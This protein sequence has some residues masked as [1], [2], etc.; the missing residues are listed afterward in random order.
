MIL[1]IVTILRRPAFAASGITIAAALSLIFLHFDEFYFV[2][3]YL[4]FYVD[5]GRLP[6]FFLDVAISGLSGIV[7][8]TSVY[9]ISTFPALKGVHRRAGL[10]GV[11]AA[12][13]AGACPC[14]Y[15]VP[16]LAVAGG[17][18]G[19]LA[20]FGI[21]FY[22]YQ[23]PIKLGSLALLAFTAFTQERSLRAACE[24]PANDL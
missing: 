15:L 3:P 11:A 24:L 21:L 19:I 5:P 4:A 22:D 17:A 9:E 8:T 13:V 18:G 12:F 20:A 23:I 6:V 14:Y 16:L 1:Q 2:S 10:L 7:I